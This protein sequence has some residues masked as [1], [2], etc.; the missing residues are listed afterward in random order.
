[1]HNSLNK[2]NETPT[3]YGWHEPC[4]SDTTEDDTM[5]LWKT[6]NPDEP[7]CHVC[8]D[9]TGPDHDCALVT[10]AACGRLTCV[11]HVVFDLPASPAD[12]VPEQ[13]WCPWCAP[14]CSRPSEYAPWATPTMFDRV[15]V[16]RIER[17]R[18]DG[19]PQVVHASG[20]RFRDACEAQRA[21]DADAPLLVESDGPAAGIETA[22]SLAECGVTRVLVRIEAGRQVVARIIHRYKD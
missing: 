1:M 20:I 9:Y 19:V 15:Q 3:T 16:A 2:T 4:D 18:A 22:S 14:A 7:R 12:H 6:P 17:M 13:A 21:V 5:T 8:A 10:C 11:D